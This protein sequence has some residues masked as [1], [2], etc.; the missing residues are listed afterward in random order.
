MTTDPDGIQDR[1]HFGRALTE[2]RERAGLTVRDIAKLVGIPPAT[3]G[4]YFAGRS[5][6]PARMSNVLA[7][8]LRACGITDPSSVRG[9]QHTL[10]R[11]RHATRT[12]NQSPP[13]VVLVLVVHNNP[14][15]TPPGE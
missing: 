4:D 11:L 9:W 8:I 5:L 12:N 13:V 7:G 2:L 10:I 3:A 15:R 14:H 1:Y 6:P